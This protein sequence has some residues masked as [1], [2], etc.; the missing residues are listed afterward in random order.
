M[1]SWKTSPSAATDDRR[2]MKTVNAFMR[3]HKKTNYT[4]KQLNT[5][6]KRKHTKH[7]QKTITNILEHFNNA[8][9]ASS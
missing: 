5:P 4:Q 8:K 9:T 6:Q 3:K 1:L 2:N 7:H